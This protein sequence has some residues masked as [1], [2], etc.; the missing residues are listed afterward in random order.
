MQTKS[1]PRCAVLISTATGVAAALGSFAPLALSHSVSQKV[2]GYS[3]TDGGQRRQ[4]AVG[5]AVDTP[6]GG[7]LS[8][9]QIYLDLKEERTFLPPEKKEA[10]G[11]K[12][13]RHSINMVATQVWDKIT[14]TSVIASGSRG[15]DLK[16]RTLGLGVKQWFH[17]E[18][19]RY[20]IDVSR[21]VVEQPYIETL[22]YDSELLIPPPVGESLGANVG[23]RHLASPKTVVDYSISHV[24]QEGRPPSYAGGIAVRQFIETFDG[25]V[26]VNG[27]RAL[28]RGPI[29][30]QTTYGQVDSWTTETAYLQNLWSGAAARFGYRYYRELEITR[31]Y[32]DHLQLGTDAVS[33]GFTQDIDDQDLVPTPLSIQAAGS[34]VLTNTDLAATTFEVGL[35]AKF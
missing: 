28:N 31:A 15:E 34:R 29:G 26:H 22:D 2:G 8:A 19:F 5:M 3:G 30:T 1:G 35:T 9:S 24:A 27:T 12:E 20:A 4:V 25:A 17:K 32:E 21:T 6:T 16:N 7:S 13:Q 11:R 10:L 23:L 18:T 14:E 33:V